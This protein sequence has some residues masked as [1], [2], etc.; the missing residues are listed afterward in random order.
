MCTQ[1]YG[2]KYS[3]SI[4]IIYKLMDGTLI[5]WTIL[6]QSGHGSNGNERITPQTFR[7]RF[8][9]LYTIYCHIRDISFLQGW[10]ILI[11]LQGVKSVYFMA[12]RQAYNW[13]SILQSNYSVSLDIDLMYKSI[14][15]I[16]LGHLFNGISVLMAYLMP[17]P[18][19]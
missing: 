11:L 9:L 12:H 3:Y 7:P 18:F 14:S 6:D 5:S 4:S 8:S 2:S 13:K 15:L 17:K 19:L 10:T 16:N 1:L